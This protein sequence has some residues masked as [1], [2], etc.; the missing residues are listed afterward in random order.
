ME[1]K[2]Y[3]QSVHDKD[4]YSCKKYGSDVM[5]TFM[6]N[7]GREFYDFFLSDQQAEILV[8]DLQAVISR[9]KAKE[10]KKTWYNK[11]LNY[12]KLKK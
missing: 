2:V 12:F 7:K 9:N 1:G 5:I 11:L 3:T 6:T 8:K 4:C 10:I